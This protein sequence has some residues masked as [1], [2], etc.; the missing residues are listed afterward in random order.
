VFYGPFAAAN[1]IQIQEESFNQELAKIRS[2][3]ETG[4]LIWDMV[5]TT[6]IN[7]A[8]GC[9]EG[10]LEKIDWSKYFDTKVF[11]DVG[12]VSECGV[13]YLFVSGGLAYDGN[14]IKDNA[15]K[16][17]ADFWN[18][19]KWPGKRGLL[20][21]AEQTFEVALMADGVP[22]AK[23][24]EVLS[25]PGGVDRALKKLEELKPHVHWWKNGAESINLLSTGEVAMAYAWNGRVA[26]ANK[27]NNLNLKMELGA[28]HVS[29]C[30]Y[31]AIMK[32]SKKVDLAYKFINIMFDPAI[33][34]EVA[35][36]K[37]GSPVVS[38]AKLNPEIAKLPGVFST[39]EQW[40]S[41]AIII[42]HKLRAAKTA[43]WRKWFA[44]NIM[45]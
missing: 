38:N 16:T 36:L 14:R 29:G 31:W 9:E 33:Q 37:K 6:A 28:G 27:T 34:A 24:M 1:K 8:T 19:T 45:N 22:P 4:N 17:W 41:Q 30:Q 39:P 15:P 40:K 3:V 20:Y 5:S 12:G 18:V 23:A 42:D 7:V 21:R 10:L 32:G 26:S 11:R 13:P 43:E 35:T 44:E 25:A 2:Q